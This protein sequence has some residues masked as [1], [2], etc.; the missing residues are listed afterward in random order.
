MRKALLTGATGFVGRYVV[1]ALLASGF[2]VRCLVRNLERSQSLAQQG[3]ERVLGDLARPETLTNIVMDVDLVI[4]DPID[5]LLI[6]C[7]Y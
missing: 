6:L 1:D 4:H 5:M 7:S 2:E 3:L